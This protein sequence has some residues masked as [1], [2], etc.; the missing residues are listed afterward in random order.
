MTR[1]PGAIQIDISRASGVV[2]TCADCPHWYAF[3]WDKIAAWRAGVDHEERC[4]P[5][6]TQARRALL[7]AERH[8]GGF[9]R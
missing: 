9:V 1:E 4:H 3:A 6:R 7:N 5:D 2:V 8:A